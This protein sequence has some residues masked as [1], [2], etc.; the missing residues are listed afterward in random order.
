MMTIHYVASQNTNIPK[1]KQMVYFHLG[2]T[3][4]FIQEM[5]VLERQWVLEFV[6]FKNVMQEHLTNVIH[7]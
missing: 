1:L 6:Q 3:K 4:V 2:C 5:E 7:M